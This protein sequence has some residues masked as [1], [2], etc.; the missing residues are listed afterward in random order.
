MT[1]FPSA[2]GTSVASHEDHKASSD[3]KTNDVKSEK[4]FDAEEARASQ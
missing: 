4:S 2:G 3:K 1:E